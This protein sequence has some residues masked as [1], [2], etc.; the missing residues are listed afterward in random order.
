MSKPTLLTVLMITGWIG[1]A[2]CS[3]LDD[4]Y[5]QS[6]GPEGRRSINGFGTFRGGVESVA[7]VRDAVR[8][9]RR[10]ESLDAIVWIPRTFGPLDKNT[11]DWLDD[12][13]SRGDATLVIVLPD[14]GSRLP[15][16]RDVF[17][18]VP[19]AERLTYRRILAAEVNE[20]LEDS[21]RTNRL[22][23]GR[24]FDAVP[25]PTL[26][27][28]RESDGA[29]E[30]A[31]RGGGFRIRTHEGKTLTAPTFTPGIGTP[32]DAVQ[33]D[34]EDSERYAVATESDARI[35]IVTDEDW[36]RSRV[37]VVGGGSLL[38]NY[39]LTRESNR[40]LAAR[41][42]DELTRVGSPPADDDAESPTTP[43]VAFVH[44]AG[45]SIAVRKPS[46]EVPSPSGMEAVTTW[47]LSLVTSHALVTGLVVCLALL[48]IFGRPRR[49]TNPHEGDF[50]GHLDAVAD[51]MSRHRGSV[52]VARERLE[53]WRAMR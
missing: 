33:S 11:R 31:P 20:A 53:R 35:G 37:V 30:P 49:Q 39:A 22:T 44:T 1:A 38:T 42:I 28:K 14:R 2:G 21:F 43:E 52:E 50:G 46:T 23:D 4:R 3:R 15:Y 45:S 29:T 17:D 10:L 40:V 51:L 13:L 16:L 41:M 26:V 32:G 34:A 25:R 6:R 18:S 36:P 5:G 47:P 7:E 12:W 48:P 24:W 19:P 9:N 27:V 8:L